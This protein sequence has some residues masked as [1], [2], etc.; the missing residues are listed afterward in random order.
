MA[1]NGKAPSSPDADPEFEEAV[2]QTAYFLWEQD[3][4]PEGRA[5]EYWVRA[6]ER[7]VRERAFDIWL[8]EGAPEG[9][10][11]EHWHRAAGKSPQ[12]GK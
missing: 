3:G 7:H 10:A 9:R 11:D 1:A 6:Y 2:R 4:K 12:P 5:H 8:R